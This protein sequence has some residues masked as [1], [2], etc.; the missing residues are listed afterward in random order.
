MWFFLEFFLLFRT[1][2]SISFG[3]INSETGRK[4][5]KVG[6]RRDREA[7]K[8]S[9]WHAHFLRRPDDAWHLPQLPPTPRISPP[10][11]RE[12]ELKPIELRHHAFTPTSLALSLLFRWFLC[13]SSLPRSSLAL[14]DRSR[15]TSVR[16]ASQVSAERRNNPFFIQKFG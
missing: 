7:T 5:G 2:W 14:A 6:D 8:N 4:A 9:T 11:K 3:Y 13:S 10:D 12:N 15:K 16:W 1:L